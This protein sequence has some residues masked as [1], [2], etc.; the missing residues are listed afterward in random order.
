MSWQHAAR[1]LVRAVWDAMRRSPGPIVAGV[2]VAGAVLT[3]PTGLTMVELRATHALQTLALSPE[4]TAFLEPG[5]SAER[6]R[7]AHRA[8]E[9][10]ALEWGATTRFIGR[11]EA[12]AAFVDSVGRDAPEMR[13]A[14]RALSQNPLPDAVVVTLARSDAARVPSLIG[15]LRAVPGVSAVQADTDWIR[16]SSEAIAGWARVIAAMQGLA[17]AAAVVAIVLSVAAVLQ[18]Q[19]GEYALMRLLGASELQLRCPAVIIGAILGTAAAVVALFASA[20]LMFGASQMLAVPVSFG[21]P[22][23]SLPLAGGATLAAALGAVGGW[24]ASRRRNL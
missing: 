5:A 15:A 17:T 19:A 23:R 13:T 11:D 2:V 14:I 10:R 20:T 18:R 1:F 3:L 21:D 12:L 16:T 9:Q 24:L 7:E 6:S 4:V 22:V 8:V